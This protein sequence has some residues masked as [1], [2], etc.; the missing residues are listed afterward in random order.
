MELMFL[1]PIFLFANAFALLIGV[2]LAEKNESAVTSR[3]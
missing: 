2:L 1:C 3:A